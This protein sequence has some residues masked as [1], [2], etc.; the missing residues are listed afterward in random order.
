[1]LHPCQVIGVVVHAACDGYHTL[2]LRATVAAVTM[3]G[4]QCGYGSGIPDDAFPETDRR[5]MK[6]PRDT[7][8]PPPLG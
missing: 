1:M 8:A 2:V 3:P 4:M 6:V 7:S 5:R